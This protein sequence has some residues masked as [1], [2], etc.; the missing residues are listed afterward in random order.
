MEYVPSLVLDYTLR[1]VVRLPLFWEAGHNMGNEVP[2]SGN[3]GVPFRRP[4]RGVIESC[5]EPAPHFKPRHQPLPFSRVKPEGIVDVRF[6]Q[7]SIHLPP[8]RPRNS[9]ISD[10]VSPGKSILSIFSP[11]SFFFAV[12]KALGGTF[13]ESVSPLHSALLVTED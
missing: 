2:S 3:E 11:P 12:A 6:C 4:N 13:N 7:L 9:H 5:A 8:P 10:P 1:C